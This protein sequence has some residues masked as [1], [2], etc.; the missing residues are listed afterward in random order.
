M[1]TA[2]PSAGPP[3]AALRVVSAQVPWCH[4][5]GAT[6][7]H[8]IKLATMLNPDMFKRGVLRRCQPQS[9]QPLLRSLHGLFFQADDRQR[10]T[11]CPV[12]DGTEFI[13]TCRSELMALAQPSRP[14][15]SSSRA[16]APQARSQVSGVGGVPGQV[17]G[18]GAGQ[19][20]GPG[21][22]RGRRPGKGGR[23][24]QACRLYR[25]NNT[26]TLVWLP[27]TL[28]SFDVAS[29]AARWCDCLQASLS[30]RAASSRLPLSRGGAA[31][32][33]QQAAGRLWTAAAAE[34][35]AGRQ[36]QQQACPRG[37]TL[38][39]PWRAGGAGVRQ[40]RKACVMKPV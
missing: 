37:P 21:K 22:A 17:W 25:P 32:L 40:L 6:Q 28:V 39:V 38:R 1:S 9:L 35:Q 14:G 27:S 15:S 20:R 12:V 5:F 8:A 18:T 3:H 31:E 11:Y 34:R 24:G 29:K 13:A 16:S 10:Y 19:A 30:S 7:V 2:P 33:Q 4:G 26:S 36:L 23:L